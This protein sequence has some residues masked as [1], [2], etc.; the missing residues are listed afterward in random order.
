M[1]VNNTL[2]L[3]CP[4][5][6]TPWMTH[7]SFRKAKAAVTLSFLPVHLTPMRRETH[8]GS[9]LE[10]MR[11]DRILSRLR[12]IKSPMSWVKLY[13]DVAMMGE[14]R[15]L[16][17]SYDDIADVLYFAVETPVEG[18]RYMD[19]DTGVLVRVKSNGEPVGI[20]IEDFR[21]TWEGRLELLVNTIS[22]RLRVS[23]EEV[24]EKLP[25]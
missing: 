8:Y 13:G 23:A 14:C 5:C 18:V 10:K 9:P 3:H 7:V 25:H 16:V 22:Q 12:T 20:T 6:K 17:A 1:W 21:Y 24:R 4:T 19:D 11:P 2:T 15:P